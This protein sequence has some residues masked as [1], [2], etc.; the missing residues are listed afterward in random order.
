MSPL[1]YFVLF[2]FAMACIAAPLAFGFVFYRVFPSKEQE[3]QQAKRDVEVLLRAANKA[4]AERC[5]VHARK[6]FSQPHQRK[7]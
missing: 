7:P 1:W 4:H 5:R 3:E 6:T 2:V